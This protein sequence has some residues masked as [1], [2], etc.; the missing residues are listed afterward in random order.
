MAS[1]PAAGPE[2]IALVQA[3]G[4]TGER[5][6]AQCRRPKGLLRN[7]D[8]EVAGSRTCRRCSG[9]APPGVAHCPRCG[10]LMIEFTGRDRRVPAEPDA[11]IEAV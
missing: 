10:G 8:G 2:R 6:C 3:R 9:T 4:P 11:T 7:S 5:L 1:E